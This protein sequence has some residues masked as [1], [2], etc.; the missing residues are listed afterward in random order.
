M[1]PGQLCGLYCWS[2]GDP[3]APT[4]AAAREDPRSVAA[5]AGLEVKKMNIFHLTSRC[6]ARK[7]PV[8]DRL[9]NRAPGCGAPRLSP[10]C[11]CL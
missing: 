3:I 9:P 7:H 2:C 4:K 10:V 1:D 11:L 5:P 8:A 6:Q